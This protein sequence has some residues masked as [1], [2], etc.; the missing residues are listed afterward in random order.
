MRM[1]ANNAL[2]QARSEISAANERAVQA[3]QQ[4]RPESELG[5]CACMQSVNTV[6]SQPLPVD[7]AHLSQ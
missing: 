7:T 1:Q 5:V 2:Q 4:V 3:K 6:S